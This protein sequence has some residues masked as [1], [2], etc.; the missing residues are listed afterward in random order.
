[1]AEVI[2]EFINFFRSI[3]KINFPDFSVQRGDLIFSCC[4]SVCLSVLNFV[5][6]QK[7]GLDNTNS[8]LSNTT[9]LTLLYSLFEFT[10]GVM[11]KCKIRP[12]LLCLIHFSKRYCGENSNRSA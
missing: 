6:F 9:K 5:I 10:V 8:N 1:M 2:I 4:P 11:Q 7:R 3:K 12:S